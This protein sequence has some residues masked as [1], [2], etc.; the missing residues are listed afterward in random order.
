MFKRQIEILFLIMCLNLIVIPTGLGAEITLSPT[1]GTDS[2]I[3]INNAISSIASNATLSDP[4]YVLLTAGTYNISAP[5]VL[6][7]NVILKGAGKQY[8]NLCYMV[9]FVTQSKNMGT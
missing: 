7:S 8:S 6:Q 9:Q 1:C 3:S 5:I 2:Q 4:G